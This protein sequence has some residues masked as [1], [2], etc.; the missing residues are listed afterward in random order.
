M[1]DAARHLLL[2]DIE[3]GREIRRTEQALE[4]MDLVP[5]ALRVA[6][7]GSNVLICGAISQP[8]EAVLLSAGVEVVPQVCGP[9]KDVLQAFLSGK[10]TEKT[11]IM[12]GCRCRRRR[13]HSG[14]FGAEPTFRV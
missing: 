1:F 7:F 4:E 6:G 13:F 8:L 12:P 3:N 10:L 5:R 11:F 14:R 9:W 2:V